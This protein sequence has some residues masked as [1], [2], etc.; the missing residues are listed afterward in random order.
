MSAREEV[1]ERIDGVREDVVFAA[2]RFEIRVRRS[3]KKA[4]E[5]V[6]SRTRRCSEPHK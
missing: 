2:R 1:L 4:A 6:S 3:V 5:R